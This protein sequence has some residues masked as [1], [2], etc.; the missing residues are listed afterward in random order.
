[1]YIYIFFFFGC[2]F[3]TLF[4]ALQA[5]QKQSFAVAVASSLSCLLEMAEFNCGGF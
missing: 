3:N 1:M 2:T 5:F 4:K